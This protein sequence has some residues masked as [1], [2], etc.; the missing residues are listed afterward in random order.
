MIKHIEHIGIAVENIEEA[1]KTYENLLGVSCYK[2]EIVESELVRTAFLKIGDS[3]IELL[4]AMDP[5]SPIGKFLAKKGEG[6]H[7]IAF[8]VDDIHA[9]IKRL[10]SLGFEMIHETPKPGADNKLIAFLHPKSTQ[11]LLVE[12][13]QEILYK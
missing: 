5:I 6:F 13:C 8:E 1:L 12:I 4:E 2:T 7:H 10:R 3:K 9:E 11:K